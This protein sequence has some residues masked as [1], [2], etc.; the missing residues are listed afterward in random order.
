M[1]VEGDG[2][3]SAATTNA[4]PQPQQELR[5]LILDCE[6]ASALD[7]SAAAVL[8][9]LRRRVPKTAQILFANANESVREALRG[10]ESDDTVKA[11][12][13]FG[14]VDHA[15]EYCED[16]LLRT[17]APPYTA[18]PPPPPPPATV[19]AAAPEPPMV[20]RTSSGRSPSGDL[21]HDGYVSVPVTVARNTPAYSSTTS[22]VEARF[23]KQLKDQYGAVGLDALLTHSRLL[24]VPPGVR[25][26]GENSHS[27]QDRS[28]SSPA[29][30]IFLDA[31][32]V[33]T[34][35]ILARPD[36]NNNNSNDPQ[37]PQQQ[38]SGSHRIAK[39]GPGAIL[40]A[41]QFVE[42]LHLALHPRDQMLASSDDEE[43]G[44][45]GSG[46]GGSSSQQP[47][48]LPSHINLVARAPIVATSDTYAQMVCLPASACTALTS[49]DPQLAIRLFSL[50]LRVLEGALHEQLV[51]QAMSTIFKVSV[52]PST[53]LTRL[54]G[55]QEQQQ[56]Q[57]QQR[58]QRGTP[59]SDE[60]HNRRGST[61]TEEEQSLSSLGL[62]SLST[63]G[64]LMLWRYQ[65]LLGTSRGAA[66]TSDLRGLSGGRKTIVSSLSADAP[67]P[68]REESLNTSS[69]LESAPEVV[70]DDTGRLH[71]EKITLSG[72]D[73]L[74]DSSSDEAE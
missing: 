52:T 6:H 71:G 9:N 59:A 50:L 73:K 38:S 10:H 26:L 61:R 8:V 12:L 63:S 43:E 53:S 30:L 13:H 33:T 56:I 37:D 67:K 51:N 1:V 15:L 68:I 62:S 42:H 22:R 40:G 41:Q 65:A 55:P 45:V 14:T 64:R 54:L 28:S 11:F 35:V 44:N 17:A 32:F 2:G 4:Q 20:R 34:S 5:F 18:S 31:G 48:G 46:G 23:S 66:S 69:G 60:R 72:L 24:V 39:Y 57:K 19:A 16:A 27:A 21:L 3:G 49:A 74:D 70:P 7:S 47:R 29:D 25:I 36:G 58:Q